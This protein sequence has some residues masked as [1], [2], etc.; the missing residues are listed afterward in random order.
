MTNVGAWRTKHECA[1]PDPSS[2]LVPTWFLLGSYLVPTWF[3]LGSYLVPTWFLLG[4]TTLAAGAT[5]HAIDIQNVE[6]TKKG[7]PL[8]PDVTQRETTCRAMQN[9]GVCVDW[10]YKYDPAT[11]ETYMQ[12]VLFFAALIGTV[13]GQDVLGCG[14]NAITDHE[15]V[16]IDH[17]CSAG[18]ICTIH[19]GVG[20]CY[21]SPK[22]DAGQFLTGILKSKWIAGQSGQY[23][24]MSYEIN[25]V[26]YDSDAETIYLAVGTYTLIGRDSYGDGWKGGKLRIIGTYTT[27]HDIYEYVTI[28]GNTAW[29]DVIT[30][31]TVNSGYA[32]SVEIQ[33]TATMLRC[34]ACAAGQYQNQND[35][36]SVECKF[37]DKGTEFAS[38]STACTDCAT[39]KYQD[40]DDAASASCKF[41]YENTEFTTKNTTCTVC[42]VGQYQK[43][44][45]LESATCKACPVVGSVDTPCGCL[46]PTATNYNPIFYGHDGSCLYDFGCM[47]EDAC[48]YNQ[49]AISDTGGSANDINNGVYS[50]LTVCAF[51]SGCQTCSGATDGSGTIVDNDD[52]EDGV[53]ND[54]EIVGCQNPLAC[55]YDENATDS[56]SC[57]VQDDCHQCAQDGSGT[58]VEDSV[59][60]CFQKIGNYHICDTCL[61]CA[62]TGGEYDCPPTK[63]YDSNNLAQ[64]DDNC[65]RFLNMQELKES[66]NIEQ[67]IAATQDFVAAASEADARTATKE[68]LELQL[69]QA[70][71]KKTI[72]QNAR[73]NAFAPLYI[74]DNNK[75]FLVNNG[76][77]K[78]PKSERSKK[79]FLALESD[80]TATIVFGNS[81]L[82]VTFDGATATATFYHSHRRRLQDLDACVSTTATYDSTSELIEIGDFII[83]SNCEATIRDTS[84]F[85]FS[86]TQCDTGTFASAE[87]YQLTN[88]TCQYC[89][90]GYGFGLTGC[91]LC[92]GEFNE[93]TDTSACDEWSTC[94]AGQKQNVAPTS[95]VNRGCTACDAGMYQAENGFTGIACTIWSL[96]AAGEKQDGAPSLSVNRGCTDCDSGRYQ[97]SDTFNGTAC[98]FCAAGFAFASKSACTACANGKYQDENTVASAS[99]KFCV[100][101][102]KFDTKAT[103][104]PDCDAGKYQTQN[105]EASV[106]CKFCAAGR[107]FNT[108][109]TDCVD[110]SG[111][112]YQNENDAPSVT[113]LT[114][115]AGTFSPDAQ[116]AC[117]DCETGK[118]QELTA[119]TEYQ[120]KF[121]DKGTEFD[122]KSTA[123][124]ACANG[125]YQDQDNAPSVTCLTCS[126]GTFSPN[127]ETACTACAEGKYQ[128]L[129]AATE[130]QCKFCVAGKRFNT[131]STDC[132]DCLGGKYQNQNDAASASCK[133]CAAGKTSDGTVCTDCDGYNLDPAEDCKPMSELPVDYQNHQCCQNCASGTE[134]N[135]AFTDGSVHDKCGC[136]AY[137]AIS[138]TP[139]I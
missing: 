31:F 42:A 113:C 2:Y 8:D 62:D 50:H 45:M 17:I 32:A 76:T 59:A 46:D 118:Y 108:K 26:T 91:E 3:L 123:C 94:N 68:M 30:D 109:A 90:P 111:G 27:D 38:K 100:A 64:S 74:V 41:C 114:C 121:C 107:R 65:C 122:T 22:C 16:C 20:T 120:C 51:K 117:G 83:K 55:N 124:T 106:E 92:D 1:S 24:D 102:K 39:G 126:A 130:Y 40:Q 132:V 136:M 28:V 70:T 89:G 13:S 12:R 97:P 119:A 116:T 81:L 58:V 9:I 75:L 134:D 110:C 128:E 60:E 129:A 4:S 80:E 77:I 66:I 53:C 112:K 85:E 139:T 14:T 137:Q 135:C 35:V 127:K 101:G 37:C 34:S 67:V 115:S 57:N 23:T 61:T 33:V 7:V 95:T 21:D 48:N 36:A 78:I 79:K 87:N 104:C 54:D 29:G 25:G 44:M 19:N 88:T 56:G 52:D 71:N 96:C 82:E 49:N 43:D 10:R 98:K 93:N 133:F 105:N 131:T 47:T 125:K 5:L 138:V 69:G 103:A 84:D 99:C 18:K 6:T 72:L 63:I 11:C 73:N 86:T 15:C